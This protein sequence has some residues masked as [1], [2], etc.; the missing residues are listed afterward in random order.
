MLGGRVGGP[1][2]ISYAFC[3]QALNESLQRSDVQ[4]IVSSSRSDRS[5]EGSN[6]NFSYMSDEL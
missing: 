1:G 6:K 4:V 2:A 5:R 3:V